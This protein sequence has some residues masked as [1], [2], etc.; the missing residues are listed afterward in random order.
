MICIESN[1]SCKIYTIY[2][3]KSTDY[4]NY[5]HEKIPVIG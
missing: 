2:A 5:H 1:R 4:A 3:K